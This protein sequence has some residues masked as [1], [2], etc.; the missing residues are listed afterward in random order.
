MNSMSEILRLKGD[1]DF[2]LITDRVG[3]EGG[4]NYKSYDYLVTF[5]SFGYRCGYV[6]LPDGH[7]FEKKNVGDIE[8]DCH[9]GVTF[10][11]NDHIAKDLVLIPDPNTWLG[12]DCMHYGDGQDM[13]SSK[14]YFDQVPDF[15]GLSYFTW[16]YK[17]VENE[18]KKNYHTTD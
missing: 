16:D 6:S 13:E 10:N 8:I 5:S 14:K 4:G 18:C 2:I 15:L 3:V 11:S 7:E 1:L 12:F 9:G 17:M